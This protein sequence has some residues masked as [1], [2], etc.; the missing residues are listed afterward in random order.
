[1]MLNSMG[2]LEAENK[3]LQGKK[4]VLGRGTSLR[5]FSF[6][7]AS[8]AQLNSVHLLWDELADF[9]ITQT[10]AALVYL[11]KKICGWIDAGNGLWVGGVRVG[12]GTLAPADHAHGWRGRV[13]RQ[14]METPLLHQKTKIAMRQQD[15]DPGM[16]T[17]A[18]TA[19]AGVFRMQRL[20]DGFVDI[21]AFKATA[22]YQTLYE[23]VGITDR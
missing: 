18:L 22:H 5:Y 20:H 3:S 21:E 8:T 23:R 16:T 11:L 6:M 10:D 17:R 1:M 19:C 7:K 14:L 15:T 12:N 13:V 9:P 2:E 4:S